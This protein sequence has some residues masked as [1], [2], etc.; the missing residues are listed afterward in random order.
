MK[1]W[2]A[3]YSEAYCLSVLSFC[4]F[5]AKLRVSIFFT[6]DLIKL[7]LST[8]VKQTLELVN[9][10]YKC[11]VAILLLVLSQPQSILISSFEQFSRVN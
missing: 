8:H 10:P 9:K 11:L 3:Y 5:T 2:I 7:L 4:F 6:K 1:I